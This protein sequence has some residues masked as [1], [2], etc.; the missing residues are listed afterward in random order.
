VESK[1][2]LYRVNDAII[3]K[4]AAIN[5]TRGAFG[6]AVLFGVAFHAMVTLSMVG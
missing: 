1:A 4:W 3:F 5:L 6:G 2:K